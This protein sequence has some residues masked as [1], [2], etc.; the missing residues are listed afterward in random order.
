MKKSLPHNGVYV[1]L[2]V[3]KVHGIGVFAIRNIPMGTAVF[4][5]DMIGGTAKGFI[6]EK[7]LKNVS[8]EIHKLYDDF[9]IIKKD[10]KG[11][12]YYGPKNFNSLTVGWYLNCDKKYS[13]MRYENDDF[14]T[15]R[16]INKGEELLINYDT[17]SDR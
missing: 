11:E 1:R 12:K 14:V 13:N 9:C 8:T 3:S 7:E 10:K 17:Y 16:W 5:T 6:R 15:T 2:G 4:A